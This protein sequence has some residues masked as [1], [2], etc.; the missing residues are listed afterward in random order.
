MLRGLSHMLKNW[1]LIAAVAAALPL[2]VACQSVGGT[3]KPS[4]RSP[5][6]LSGVEAMALGT[7]EWNAWRAAM[8]PSE[9]ASFDQLTASD[10]KLRFVRQNG[11][12]VRVALQDKLSVGMSIEEAEA[13]LEGVYD[14]T[15]LGDPRSG[16]VHCS[17]NN[18]A[19]TTLIDL[20]FDPE[21]WTLKRWQS[22]V[23]KA[24]RDTSASL[25]ST[26]QSRLDRVLAKGMGQNEVVASHAKAAEQRA[27]YE[28]KLAERRTNADYKGYR[29]SSASDFST[30]AAFDRANGSVQFWDV[31]NRKPEYIRLEGQREYWYHKVPLAGKSDTYIVIEYRFENKRLD[32]WWVYSTD[33]LGY[34]GFK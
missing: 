13:A 21:S 10:D 15:E 18:G 22:H 29:S 31:L 24:A 11:V 25:E 26:L 4:D 6:D 30:E 33:F 1:K 9:K 34:T 2:A 12:D 32:S 23:R 8:T 27:A 7:S 14:T 5:Y 28:R 3:S 19:S 17:V 16:W 20:E